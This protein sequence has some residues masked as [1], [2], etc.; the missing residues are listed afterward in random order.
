V[1]VRLGGKVIRGQAT[2]SLGDEAEL[3]T[4]KA[5]LEQSPHDAKPYG[6][7]LGKDGELSKSDA[8]A[9]LPQVVVIRIDLD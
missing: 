9:L 5:F 2:V 1:E 8:C 4:V 7:E 3:P 6:V